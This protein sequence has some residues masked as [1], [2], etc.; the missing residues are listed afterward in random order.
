ME[1]PS[2]TWPEPKTNRSVAHG[3]PF[4]LS[5]ATG[6]CQIPSAVELR[7]FVFINDQIF[8]SSTASVLR[9][10]PGKVHEEISALARDEPAVNPVAL[11][12]SS[13]GSTA[14]SSPS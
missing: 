13:E 2:K 12:R 11:S 9:V 10:G 8:P 1:S 3:Q 7:M 5:W 4:R 14:A 6:G